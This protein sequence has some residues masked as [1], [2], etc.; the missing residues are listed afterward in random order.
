MSV[1]LF[2]QQDHVAIVTI[3]RPEARN[4]MDPE[5]QVRLAEAWL[6]VRDDDSIR[7]A[8]ITG[9]GGK[10]FCSGAD[11]GKLIP[12]YSGARQ[13]EDEFDKAVMSDRGLGDRA[14]LR[15][16]DSVKPVIAAVD[17]YAIAGGMELMQGTDIRIASEDAKVGVQEVKWGIFP[18]GGSSVRLPRQMPFAI[19]MELLLTGD[20]ID[21]QRAYELGLFNRVV[22]KAEVMSTALEFA[23]KI[24]EN[25]PI[26]VRA[27][28]KSAKACLG[29]PE[30]EALAME[31]EFAAPVFATRDAQEGPRAFM[32]KRKPVFEGR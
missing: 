8:I 22:P 27:I 13:P 14:I 7:V 19:A 23:T 32:E 18:A 28:R 11:L 17:G 4:A 9:A 16:F 20:L 6:R 31:S 24:A 12:L 2:E 5:V 26:A 3:N 21:A 30:D 15:R 10:S 1:V 25:G 29:R